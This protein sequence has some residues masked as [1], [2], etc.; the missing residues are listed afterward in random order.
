MIN[1]V[2]LAGFSGKNARTRAAQNGRNV[3]KLSVAT[4]KRHKDADGNWQEKTQWHTSVC[5]GPTADYAANIQTGAHVFIE[6]EL[7]YRE[8]ERTI[9]TDSGPVKAP[10]PV[11]EIVIDSISVLDRKRENGNARGRLRPFADWRPLSAC[12]KHRIIA[13]SVSAGTTSRPKHREF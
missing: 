5:C 13:S 3:T 12:T 7:V 11:T 9:E 2:T 8:Y 4:S 6:G 10:W 1:R